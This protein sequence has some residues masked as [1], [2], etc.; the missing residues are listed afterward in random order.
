M[1]QTLP[2]EQWEAAN[3]VERAGTRDR[4]SALDPSI[5]E[6]FTALEEDLGRAMPVT[7][8]RDAIATDRRQVDEMLERRNARS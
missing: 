8:L 3:F 5:Y 4:S 1:M 2:P 7:N 6:G